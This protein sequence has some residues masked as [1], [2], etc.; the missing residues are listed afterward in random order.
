ME[1]INE[2]HNTLIATHSNAAHV[3]QLLRVTKKLPTNPI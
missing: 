2:N 1:T 3:T